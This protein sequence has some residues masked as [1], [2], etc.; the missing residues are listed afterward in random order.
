[1]STEDKKQSNVTASTKTSKKDAKPEVAT[2]S[3]TKTAKN[4][5]EMSGK[6]TSFSSRRIWPD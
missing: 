4:S 3:S 1:M 6:G 2:K 5:D